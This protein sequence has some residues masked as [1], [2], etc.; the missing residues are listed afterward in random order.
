MLNLILVKYCVSTWDKYFFNY[1]LS[2]ANRSRSGTTTN[3]ET[4]VISVWTTFK[5]L[6]M[7]NITQF[8][9]VHTILWALL[10][11]WRRKTENCLHL[12]LIRLQLYRHQ[13]H[14]NCDAIA[15]TIRPCYLLINLF[16]MYRIGKIAIEG[17]INYNM[18]LVLSQRWWYILLKF[19]LSPLI[20]LSSIF[21]SFIDLFFYLCILN[22]VSSHIA[23]R[24][25]HSYTL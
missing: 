22:F 23:L 25:L 14:W 4:S 15:L 12:L 9:S 17:E 16:R 5:G 24:D 11:Q 7:N 6:I 13:F 10:N 18:A 8:Q 21:A 20:F 1:N 2:D 19:C 3:A